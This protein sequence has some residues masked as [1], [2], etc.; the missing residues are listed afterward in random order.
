MP[1]AGAPVI[2]DYGWAI[3]TSCR[4]LEL[5]ACVSRCEKGADPAEDGKEDRERKRRET[6]APGGR[7]RSAAT[8]AGYR[9]GSFCELAA[10]WQPN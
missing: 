1:P 6:E 3:S 10:M 8:S 5:S 4:A 7:V 2:T 9:H